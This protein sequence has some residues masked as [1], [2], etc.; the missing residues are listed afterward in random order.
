MKQGI[1]Y[2]IGRDGVDKMDV[3]R[4]FEARHLERNE[5]FATIQEMTLSR[6]AIRQ[7]NFCEQRTRNVI[8][9]VTGTAEIVH[10]L[11]KAAR[12]VVIL[13]P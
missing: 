10:H 11:P 12:I 9:G 6:G 5:Q 13:E 3:I 8:V 4:T 1:T 7:I 2:V